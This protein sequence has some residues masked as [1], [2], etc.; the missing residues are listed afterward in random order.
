MDWESLK[1]EYATTSISMR[2]LAEKYGINANLLMRKAR[3]QKWTQARTQAAKELHAKTISRI[4]SEQ[5]N[6][7]SRMMRVADKIMD[8][9]EKAT[10]GDVDTQALKQLTGALKDIRDIQGIELHTEDTEAGESGVVMLPPVA[11]LEPPSDE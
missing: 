6:R 7:I 3:T 5:S 10:E 2:A 11:D 9:I 8:A 4:V 1:N